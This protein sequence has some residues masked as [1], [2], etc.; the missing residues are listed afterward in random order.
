MK[1]AQLIA[2]KQ[3]QI[4]EVPVPE[5]ERNNDVLVRVKSVGICG[6]DMHY[7]ASGNIGSLVVDFPFT[8]GHEGAGIVEKVGEEVRHVKPGDRV[9]IEPSLSCGVCSQCRA[10]RPHTC[11]N[12]KFM[13]CPGQLAGNLSEWMVVKDSQC[14]KLDS[15]L[16]F[17][18]GALSE[19]LS[20]GLYANK[21]ANY[22]GGQRVGI[23]GFGPIGMSVLL[24]SQATVPG[25]YFVTDKINERL[26]IAKHSGADWVGNP[27]LTDVALTIKKNEPE[28]LDVVFECCGQQDA[29]DTAIELVKPGGKIMIIGIPEFSSWTFNAEKAR[30]KEI[31]IIHVRRQNNCVEDTLELMKAGK[32]DASKLITHHFDLE[33]TQEAFE[34]VN[35]Y[36]NGVMKAVLHL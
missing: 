28:L 9:V 25:T 3:I 29:F 8:P 11:L 19:P 12:N 34:W 14:L 2:L 5:I 1:S 26:E 30:R 24:T 7:Y 35:E 4:N 16:S 21:Q 32:L 36:K 18:D 6:S 13:G 33:Q 22:S 17:E 20:I 27:M 23:L 31:S 10:G 15:A